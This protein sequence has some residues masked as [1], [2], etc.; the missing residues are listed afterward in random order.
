MN[1]YRM[2][3]NRSALAGKSSAL[4]AA[5]ILILGSLTLRAQHLQEKLFVHTDK[6]FY[7][8]G[9]ICW[10]KLYAVDAADH[11]PLDLS[12]LAYLEW[13]DKDNKP[14][15]QAKVGLSEGHGDGSLYLPLTLRSGNYKLRAYTNWMKNDGPDGFFEKA[16]TVVNAR[17]SAGVPPAPAPATPGSLAAP[18]AAAPGS[19]RSASTLRCT[20]S[21][22][23]EGGNLVENI[24][25]KVAFKVEDQYGRGMDCTGVIEEDDQDT[26]TRFRPLRFGIG[27]FMLTPRPGHRYRSTV[28][29][30]DGTAVSTLLPAANQEGMVMSVSEEG[31]NQLRVNVQST[32][33]PAAPGAAQPSAAGIYLIASTRQSVRLT[34]TASLREGKASFLLPKDSLGEGISQL[35]LSNGTS[36]PVCA[37]LVFKFPAHPLHLDIST[38]QKEY[39]TRKKISLTI[40]ATTVNGQ[41]LPGA[42]GQ[43][44]PGASGQPL[45][46]DCSL[47][48]FRLD[49]MQTVPAGHIE[50]YLWLVSDLKGKI[51]SPDYYFEHPDDREA[52]DNLMLSHG[53]RKFRPSTTYPPEYNGAIISGRIVDSKTGVAATRPIQGYLSLPGTRTQ[54]T[55][56]YCDYEGKVVFEL[57]DFYGSQQMIVQT[58]PTED[59]SFRVDISNPFLDQYS[60]IPLPPLTL[61]RLDSGFLTEKSLDMQVLNRYAGQRLKQF[62]F[63]A[64]DT[65]SFYDKPDFSYLLDDYTRFVTMEEVMREYV[66][67]IEVRRRNGHFHLPFFDIP[68]NRFFD[69]DPLIL[70]DGVPIFNIDS[71]M[72]MDPLK[73]RKVETIQRKY[74]LG[75]TWF[76]GVMNWT[77]YKGDLGG[78]VLDPHATVV[79]YEGLQ[80]ER[81][82]YNPVYETQQQ[83]DTH[84]PDFRNVLY[85]S[86]TLPSDSL[87][88][89]T[90]SFYSSDI[91]GKYVVV[92][93]GLSADGA[94]GSS[95][96]SFEVK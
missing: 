22:F 80:L 47:S 76:N 83:A 40:S 78:Y 87:G 37:R 51:E 5:L 81:E 90:L 82:F 68:N 1:H 84:L 89:K 64:V 56:A 12:K 96:I 8:A 44:L 9:E 45:T 53:W 4:T 94:A 93:E 34:R 48:V 71:L 28:R 50:P 24:S 21:F 60:A 54:F 74:F 10:F 63:S 20:V 15:L 14:V 2:I 19:P 32:P 70:V 23:P 35:T 38:D 75:G 6:E 52:M 79:D 92:V 16:I 73:F 86:P 33:Q 13:L 36:Q 29:L 67:M 26:T 65:T 25:S 30:A 57:K 77:T 3:Y 49:S 69:N 66:T 59:S 11:H 88:N 17:T 39:A 27:S 42:S 31:N 61:P 41:L 43:L 95:L 91:P 55:S 58:D 46:T 85:W 62:H 7:L 18:A 72:T